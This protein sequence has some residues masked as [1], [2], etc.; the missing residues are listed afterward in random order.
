MAAERPDA[1]RS[2]AIRRAKVDIFI[3]DDFAE[4]GASVAFR[5]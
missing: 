1:D 3:L 2:R 4:V 5:E